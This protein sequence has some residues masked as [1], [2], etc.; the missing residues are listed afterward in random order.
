LHGLVLALRLGIPAVA[1]DVVRGGGKVTCQAATIGWPAILSGRGADAAAV[2]CALD[3]CLGTEGRGHAARC[4][5]TAR[6]RVLETREE[7]L[8]ALM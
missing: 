7:F 5:A 8:G 3:W 1:I 4:A 6:R 2:G